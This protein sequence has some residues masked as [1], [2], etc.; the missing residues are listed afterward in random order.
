[1][2]D[3]SFC[4]SISFGVWRVSLKSQQSAWLIAPPIMMMTQLRAVPRGFDLPAALTF[5]GAITSPRQA[6]ASAALP[7]FSISLRSKSGF[8]MAST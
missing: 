5:G 6:A 4:T 3:V 7:H 1:M 8:D 2:S